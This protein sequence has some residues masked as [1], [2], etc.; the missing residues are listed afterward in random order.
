MLPF[1]SAL[2]LDWTGAAILG[3][4]VLQIALLGTTLFMHRYRTHNAIEW[5]HPAVIAFFRITIWL[6][7]GVTVRYWAGEHRYHHMHTDQDGD[8]HSPGILGW[9]KV[10]FLNGLFYR[11]WPK[12]PENNAYVRRQKDL[13]PDKWD[14]WFFDYGN[15]AI[16]TGIII[17]V[18]IFGWRA[19]IMLFLIDGLG[20]LLAGGIINSLGHKFGTKPWI[21][22]QPENP[23]GSE[24]YLR[25]TE[26][27]VGTSTNLPWLIS[28]PFLFI[29]GEPNH[30]NHHRFQ[31]SARFSIRLKY[32]RILR[33]AAKVLE[34]QG[35]P[36]PYN[37]EALPRHWW[38]NIDPT[39]RVIQLLCRLHL[40]RAK[41]TTGDF[42]AV[43]SYAQ[44]SIVAGQP[45]HHSA[46]APVSA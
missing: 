14:R 18:V 11:N 17:S 25:S 36:V 2:R 15:T 7:T 46:Q 31:D 37:A 34:A 13:Q 45:K 43:L 19:G 30:N 35:R 42:D 39:W 8:P 40:A 23:V 1:L 24:K 6:F 16:V 4:I 41:E 28:L 9:V 3:I 29:G 5:L 21:I 12:L 27:M 33:Q 20:Y 44:E 38:Q 26:K 32:V 22:F 10:L